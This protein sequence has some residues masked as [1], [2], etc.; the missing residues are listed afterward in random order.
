MAHNGSLVVRRPR[1]TQSIP[2]P[3]REVVHEAKGNLILLALALLVA[4]KTPVLSTHVRY[5]GKLEEET[6]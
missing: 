4:A 6:Y 2:T 1:T 5:S 3:S